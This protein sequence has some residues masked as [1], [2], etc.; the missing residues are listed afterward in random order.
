M[1]PDLLPLRP[2]R[3]DGS[4]WAARGSIGRPGFEVA[5][6]SEL[7][8]REAL[9]PAAHEIAEQLLDALLPHLPLGVV[10]AVDLPYLHRILMVAAQT[11][12]GIGLVEVRS[13]AP[14]EGCV[15]RRTWGVLW[16]ALG[17][18]PTLPAPQRLSVA[19]LVQAGHWVVRT[20][21][22]GIDDLA[23]ALQHDPP[24]GG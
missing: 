9:E 11:G 23:T 7:G 18:L 20:G 22:G 10:D 16:T 4:T 1:V 15:D 5:T 3:L 8:R 13:S 12:A 24:A 19:Y 21:T 2:P 6:L 17:D 14:P